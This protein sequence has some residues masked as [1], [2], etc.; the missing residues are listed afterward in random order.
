M[1]SVVAVVL[2]AGRSKR[3]KSTKHKLLHTV[4]GKP[5]VQY[6]QQALEELG[7]GNIIYV[8]GHQA[9][10]LRQVL[11][12][13]AQY[14]DQAKQLGTGHALMQTEALLCKHQG[15][16]LVLNGDHPLFTVATLKYFLKQKQTRSAAA[17][18]TVEVPFPSDYG[19]IIRDH[20]GSVKRLVET[21]DATPEELS[22]SEAS[23]GVFCFESQKVFKALR[24]VQNKNAQNEYYLPDVISILMAAGEHV[25]AIKT[26]ACE[27]TYGVNN[28]VQLSYVRKIIQQRIL[29]KLMLNG[30]TIIDPEHTYIDAEVTVGCDTVIEPGCFLRGQTTIGKMCSIGPCAEL[31]DTV[32]GDRCVV[33]NSTVEQALIEDD[34]RIGPYAYIRPKCKIK[35]K[36]Q[37]GCFIDLKKA[38]IGEET[39]ITHLAYVGD[40]EIGNK[41]NIGCGVV[42]VNY[43]GHEKN[44]T[45]ISNGAFVGCN[46]NLIAP[47]KIGEGSYIAAGSTIVKGVPDDALA[48]ARSRQENKSGYAS[49]LLKKES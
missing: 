38:D 8:V 48:I 21:R 39:K 43:N 28:R 30:V 15:E 18:L 40:A 17:V 4:C 35:K 14:V 33:R 7:V 19:R 1:E 11:G 22:V 49:R 42:T 23:T 27:Q 10:D 34:V 29:E 32:L 16:L 25:E 36:A 24:K 6:L 3:M 37:I 31:Y 41:V 20:T 9:D 2:A 44:K 26:T 12:K 5:I 46:V 47:V 13:R 45:Y